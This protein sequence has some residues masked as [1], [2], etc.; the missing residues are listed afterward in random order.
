[1]NLEDFGELI[2]IEFP[3]K[4]SDTLGGLLLERLEHFPD[5]GEIYDAPEGVDFKILSMDKKR[6][7]TVLVTKKNQSPAE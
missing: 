4:D 2:G 7:E 6:I 3:S 5:E 1:M